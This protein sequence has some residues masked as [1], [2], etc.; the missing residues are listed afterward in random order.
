MND[1]TQVRITVTS[2]PGL[3]VPFPAVIAELRPPG[4]REY[5]ATEI[6]AR[7]RAFLPPVVAARLALPLQSG[8]FEAVVAAIT[9]ALQDIHGANGFPAQAT[10]DERGRCTI[11]IGYADAAAAFIALQ[12]ALDLAAALF[13]TLAGA[14]VDGPA[15]ARRLQDVAARMLARQPDGFIRALIRAA[16]ERRIPVLPVAPGSR[17]WQFGQGSRGIHFFEAAS[18][19]D[20]MTGTRLARNKL[21]SNQLITALGLP[22]VRHRDVASVEEARRVA[23]ELGYPVVVKPAKGGKGQGVTAGIGEEAGIGPAFEA[24]SAAGAGPVLVEAHVAGD[25]HRLVAIGGTFAW[26]VRRA[27]PRVQGDGRSTIA[28]LVAAENLRR[29]A[30]LAAELGAGPIL[31][32]ADATALLAARGLTAASVPEA[33]AEVTLGRVANLARGGTLTDC[34]DAVHPDNR[35]MAEALARAFRL[36]AIGIDF[37]TPDITRSWRDV[38]CGVIE[39]NATPGFSSDERAG[40]VIRA[41]FP[42]GGHD[43]RI[44]AVVLVGDPASIE[45]AVTQLRAAAGPGV[46]VATRDG[47]TLAGLV[48]RHAAA[49]LP[50]QLRALVLDK[51]C[52]ALVAGTTPG[53][54]A[55]GGFPLDRCLLA[56]VIGR[57]MLTPALRRLVADCAGSVAEA[58]DAAGA[59]ALALAA[60]HE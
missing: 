17:V 43:G 60:L 54:I 47:A 41:R 59:V 18:E 50:A 35:A 36:D 11:A 13:R 33:G 38:A 37:L 52:T 12:A 45:A 56:V 3:A 42:P 7:L 25:D 16:S 32:D 55:Q 15:L 44:P 49:E 24:A 21:A 39:V 40:R 22:G 34:T 51:C 30:S 31:L 20:A 10:R 2:G 58:A 8:R 23:R 6:G 48:R 26:A 27:P 14:P 5:P 19:R 1:P 4:G 46:G 9:G 53:E 28:E 29:K 57:E